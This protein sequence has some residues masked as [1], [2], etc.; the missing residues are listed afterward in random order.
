MTTT[1]PELDPRFIAGVDMI[2]RS[3]S[4]TF[5]IRY[6]DDQEPV[7]WIAVGGWPGGRWE[8]AGAIDPVRAVLRLVEQT[9][10]GG[11]CTH[12]KMPVA[13]DPD[14]LAAPPEPLDR[15]ACWY[16]FDPELAVIRRGCE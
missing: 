16:Q 4:E 11:L 6:Q 1:N 2:R 15:M 10:D 5:Q 14:D 8:A 12:C 13:F 7:V 3:G 9:L